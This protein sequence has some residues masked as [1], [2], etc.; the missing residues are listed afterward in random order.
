MPF[1]FVMTELT[2]RVDDLLIKWDVPRGYPRFHIVAG[3]GIEMGYRG[4][5]DLKCL[6]KSGAK[7]ARNK[8]NW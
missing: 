4:K 2:G 6:R 1:G 7:E 3:S 5:N 8:E